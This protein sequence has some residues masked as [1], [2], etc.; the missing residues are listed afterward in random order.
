MRYS[1][2]DEEVAINMGAARRAALAAATANASNAAAAAAN[3]TAED[4]KH[5]AINTIYTNTKHMN[6]DAAAAAAAA[7]AAVAAAPA[8]AA[9]H[10]SASAASCRNL[11]V[12]RQWI[13][14]PHCP[15]SSNTN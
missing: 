1:N 7:V 6:S 4:M 13:Y 11:S 15:C 14:T 8:A 3:N 10:R 2:T 9:A 12:L 5:Q